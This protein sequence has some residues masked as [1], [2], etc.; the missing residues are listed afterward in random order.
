MNKKKLLTFGILSFFAI[1]LVT[2]GVV[3]Y[4]GQFRDNINVHSPIEVIGLESNNLD[5]GSAGT[6]IEGS[7]FT[8]E[9]I[10]DFGVLVGVSHDAEE[11]IDVEY[12]STLQLTKKDVDFNLDVWNIPNDA[13]KVEIEYTIVGSEFN[14]EVIEDLQN[15][16]GYVLVYYADNDDRFANPGEAVLVEDVAGDLPAVGDE[17]VAL[18][19][20]S[21]EYPTTPNGAKI[22]YVPSSALNEGVIDWSMADEFYFESKLI[23]YN[24]DGEIIMYPGMLLEINPEY[25]IDLNF[26]GN[27]TVTNYVENIELA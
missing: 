27:T 2:A 15:E 17:N 13:E 14:A 23:Q 10:E 12:K 11:G 7:S 20:Y 16:D 22:W 6:T 26:V 8:I 24:S 21:A 9:N 1:A 19:D 3:L 4:Q 25:T 18:N 5:D